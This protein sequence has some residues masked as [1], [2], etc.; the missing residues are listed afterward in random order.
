MAMS[1]SS[2]RLST[3]IVFLMALPILYGHTLDGI[4][5][6]DPKLAEMA[7]VFR[8]S[9]WRQARFVA[10]PQVLPGFMTGCRLALGLCWKA[11]A[12]AEVIGMPKGSIGERLQQAKVYLDTPDL[13]AW[14][15]AIV[16]ASAACAKL[17][18][19]G[20]KKLAEIEKI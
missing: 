16:F 9:P 20:L 15:L 11:G 5:R 4:D 18:R 3:L 12:A 8:L 13:F 14:T 7:R 19:A 6:L 17:L 2:K 10:L 1:A